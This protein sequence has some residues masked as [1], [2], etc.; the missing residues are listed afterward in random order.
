MSGASL[1]RESE[2]RTERGT[3]IT[4]RE[5]W[6]RRKGSNA[7]R[8]VQ[9]IRSSGGV[10]AEYT[11]RSKGNAAMVFESYEAGIFDLSTPLA[12]IGP[13]LGR[14]MGRAWLKAEDGQDARL[15]VVGARDCTHATEDGL[16]PLLE[17]NVHAGSEELDLNSGARETDYTGSPFCGHSRP[18]DECVACSAVLA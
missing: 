14:A 16:I 7:Y 18:S 6:N 17:P 5:W 10:L 2:S 8:V 4:I 13:D 15:H 1:V 9:A 3:A 12:D 11:A